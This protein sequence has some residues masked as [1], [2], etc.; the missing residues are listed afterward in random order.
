MKQDI[1]ATPCIRCGKTRVF[2]KSWVEKS[3][4][5]EPVTCEL[6]VCPDKECQKIVDAHFE[7]KR[8]KRQLAQS[9]DSNAA[10]NLKI[11]EKLEVKPVPEALK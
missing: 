11:D 1:F 3:D 6:Y 8:E 5:G 2:F 4:R 9:G 10:K 7:A